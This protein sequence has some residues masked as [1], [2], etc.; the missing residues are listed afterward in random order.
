MIKF[1]Y[2]FFAISFTLLFSGCQ[3]GPKG[4]TTILNDATPPAG[5]NP[6]FVKDRKNFVPEEVTKSSIEISGIDT[7][8]P[9]AVKIRFHIIE[10]GSTYLSG[11][12]Q[13]QFKKYWCM[14]VDSTANKEKTIANYKLKEITEEQAIPNYIALVADHSGSMGDWRAGAVQDAFESLI[15][16]KRAEDAVTIVK[17]DNKTI[18]EVPL[19]N[20]SE[21][22]M[23]LFQKNKLDGFGGM[24]AI[25][26]GIQ[27]GI[28]ELGKAPINSNKSVVIFTDGW[29]NSSTIGKDSVI[30]YAR[31][32]N[33]QIYAID[34]GENI[35][36]GYMKTFSDSANGYYHHI[37]NTKEFDLVFD[38]VYNRLKN[39][40]EIEYNPQV[41]SKHKLKLKL[42]LPNDTL[43]KEIEFDNTPNL[44][45]IGLLSIYFDFDKASVKKESDEAIEA[46]LALMKGYPEMEIE[47][48][49]HT[50]NLN[51]T[52]DPDYN[53]KL[54]QKRADA[55]KS[56][57][58]KKG[59]KE[60]RIKTKGYGETVPIADNN[61]E[62]GRAMN[63]R[64][65]FIVLK[66]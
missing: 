12:N 19:T 34:F 21:E 15:K 39:Y 20:S 1:F 23:K 62:E 41:Y 53:I 56:I 44:G 13:K 65:E 51:G 64:T 38:D 30:R 40:Y 31:Q 9:N 10:N 57:L 35:N 24:T 49:G 27:A 59:I 22:A 55:V 47:L 46:I 11:A 25:S 5:Y 36:S 28:L 4:E 52:K 63:R 6:V 54:S 61:S 16:R 42:C 33:T 7:R 58:V 43:Y 60:S 26:N 8:Q 2:I 14:I 45:S 18:T 66:K 50:D 17:Y 29:D 32:A 48:R 37:Y 3:T